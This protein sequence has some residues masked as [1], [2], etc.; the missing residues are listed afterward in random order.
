MERITQLGGILMRDL[1][2]RGGDNYFSQ[3]LACCLYGGI[4]LDVLKVRKEELPWTLLKCDA[5]KSIHQSVLPVSEM[6]KQ[7][8]LHF[9]VNN[10]AI[11]SDVIKLVEVLG[12]PTGQIRGDYFEM[13]VFNYITTAGI[14]RFEYTSCEETSTV[15]LTSLELQKKTLY[16]TDV[17]EINEDVNACCM[18]GG[19]IILVYGKKVYFMQCS[20]ATYENVV[21]K[22]DFMDVAQRGWI[23][24]LVTPYDLSKY[25]KRRSELALKHKAN[26]FSVC[27][28]ADFLLPHV[29][30]TVYQSEKKS[31]V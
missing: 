18:K 26:K 3:V 30:D 22:K 1:E 17:S 4:G 9:L 23:P 25:L 15:E 10:T 12:L 2:S 5:D 6:A 20:V 21:E 13:A 8:I 31:V 7:S 29:I 16:V 11:A 27:N 28:A 24:I 19:D 14:I